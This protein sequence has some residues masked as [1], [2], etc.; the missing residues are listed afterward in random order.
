MTLY[1]IPL[2]QAEQSVTVPGKE[3]VYGLAYQSIVDQDSAWCNQGTLYAL[4]SLGNIEPEILDDRDDVPVFRPLRLMMPTTLMTE[5]VVMLG[6]SRHENLVGICYARDSDDD[7]PSPTTAAHVELDLL[8]FILHGR[9]WA[10]ILPPDTIEGD[11]IAS[12]LRTVVWPGDD[13]VDRW[14][15]K[16]GFRT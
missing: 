5:E 13:E 14:L 6:L 16:I 12:W 15:T 8:T 4:E 3:T 11:V 1:K 10:I 9:R 7:L 2:R